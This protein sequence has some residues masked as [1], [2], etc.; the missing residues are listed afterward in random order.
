MLVKLFLKIVSVML[1][2]QAKRLRTVD[3]AK[4]AAR[5]ES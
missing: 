2:Q 5:A 1:R 3:G 4:M